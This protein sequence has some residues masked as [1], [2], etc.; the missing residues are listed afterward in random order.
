MLARMKMTETS[1]RLAAAVTAACLLAGCPR[2]GTS[3]PDTGAPATSAA[4]AASQATLAPLA[5]T[6]TA[7]PSASVVLPLV[8]TAT[9]PTPTH[10][11]PTAKASTTASSGPTAT[12]TGA[13][14][15]LRACCAALRKQ[16]AERPAQG[17]QLNQA[18][19]VCEGLVAAMAGNGAA[20]PELGPVKG[21]LQGLT[22]PP[23][24]QGL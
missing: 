8:E 18:A 19:A 4:P 14:T 21:L 7:P 9:I 6:A 5:D 11:L 2:Q 24:C 20:M 22:L 10:P 17:A 15:Q 3:A 13:Q 1:T 16:A 12:P 23:V